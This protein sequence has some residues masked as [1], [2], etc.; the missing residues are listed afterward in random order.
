MTGAESSV[1]IENLTGNAFGVGSAFGIATGTVQNGQDAELSFNGTLVTRD[2]NS[3]LID[4]IQYELHAESN[5]A[6]NFSIQQ[7][8]DG[9]IDKIKT[10]ITNYNEL[11]EE[12]NGK[13]YE[14]VYSE[15]EP[16]TSNQRSS[17]SETDLE[18]WEEKGKSGL[19]TGTEI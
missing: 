3:F 14:E 12:L 10:F 5:Q 11:I 19:L 2:S 8:I 7:D 4:G 13:I 15:Y 17:M 16:L 6:A 9:T 1:E 18:N